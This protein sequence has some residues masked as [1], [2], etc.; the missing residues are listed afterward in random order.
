M[1]HRFMGIQESARR[2]GVEEER[3]PGDIPVI[4]GFAQ[5]TTHGGTLETWQALLEGMSGGQKFNV[6]NY[7]TNIAAPFQDPYEGS[8]KTEQKLWSRPTALAVSLSREAA[9]MS[10]IIGEDG[11]L[12]PTIN[13][14]RVGLCI[15]SG[16]G[17][18]Q[19]LIDVKDTIHNSVDKKTD[20]K[21]D[22]KGGSHDVGPFAGLRLFPEQINAQVAQALGCSGWPINTSEACA[23]GAAG[24]VEAAR[25]IREGKAD[26]VLAGGVEDVIHEHPDVTMAIFAGL[27]G[28]LS[29]RNEDPKNASRPFDDKRD[30]FLISSGGGIVIV[31]GMKH[32]LQREA[33]PQ[34]VV[35]GYEK[36]IDGKDPTNL[37]TEQVARTIVRALKD[38]ETGEYFS[39]DAIFAHATSTKAGDELEA[40]AFRL[41]FEEELDNIPITAIKGALGHTLGAA[42]AVNA[43]NAILAM[44]TGNIPPIA[45]LKNVDEKMKDLK[46]VTGKPLE[47]SLKIVGA[48]AYGFGGHNAVVIFGEYKA[49]N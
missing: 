43:I 24:I 41:A 38:K 35:L 40:E 6:E 23:T 3:Y 18:S 5:K 39:L 27:R 15:S 13:A 2:L 37:D 4:T 47:K 8:S 29:T 44:K 21:K 10:R 30:G 36:S 25:L 48:F 28:A 42:G 20:K 11:R 17:A 34:A 49:D 46:L 22:A 26:I 1:M 32:A 45:N 14:R 19:Q 7:R 31:E 16:I 33:Y 12:L 9:K